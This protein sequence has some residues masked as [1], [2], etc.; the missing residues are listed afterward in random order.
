MSLVTS[1]KELSTEPDAVSEEKM[2]GRTGET[3]DQ[4]K[5]NA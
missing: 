2:V 4:M 3:G 5:R 1:T